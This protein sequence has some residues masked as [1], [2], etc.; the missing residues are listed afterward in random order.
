M[1][2]PFKNYNGGK[3]G[4]GTYQQIINTIPPHDIF[5]EPFLGNGAI[6]RKIKPAAMASIGIDIDASVILKWLETNPSIT[7]I[8]ADAISWLQHFAPIAN[9]LK[10]IGIKVLIYLDPPYPME[11]RKSKNK[12][13]AYEMSTIDH[14]A[15]IS[16]ILNINADILISSYANDIYDNMLHDWFSFTFSSTTR[17]GLA[18]EKVWCNYPKPSIL[19]DYRY[20]G[21]SFREREQIKRIQSGTISK[22]TAMKDL[23]R[24][25]MIYRLLSEN[26]ISEHFRKLDPIQNH[27]FTH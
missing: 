9:I 6:M 19:H 26:I 25:A 22:L 7:A 15:L 8:N 20:I 4:N 17:K 14:I 11:C 12:L 23:Q 27:F 21:N 1:N 5:I 10:Q 18:T 3:D 24:N 16:I 2:K 13:Y